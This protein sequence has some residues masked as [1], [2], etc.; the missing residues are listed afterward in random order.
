M[1]KASG[2]A[3]S[4]PFGGAVCDQREQAERVRTL[5]APPEAPSLRELAKPSGFD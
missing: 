4:S 3:I 5:P 1:L 2:S